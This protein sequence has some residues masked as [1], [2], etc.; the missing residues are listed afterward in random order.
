MSHDR[1]LKSMVCKADIAFV[2]SHLINKL[3]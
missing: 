3:M 1:F 2:M